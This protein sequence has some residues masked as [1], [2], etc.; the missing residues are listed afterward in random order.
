[1]ALFVV[2]ASL[3]MTLGE[4]VT[5]RPGKRYQPWIGSLREYGSFDRALSELHFASTAHEMVDST[6]FQL[7]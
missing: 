3:T 6:G 4:N 1:M 5:S 2:R 7:Y